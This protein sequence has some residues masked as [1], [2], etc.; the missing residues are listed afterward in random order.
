MTSSLKWIYVLT[1][2]QAI[3]GL[4]A[5]ASIQTG[6]GFTGVD[7][8]NNIPLRILPLGASI[9]WGQNSPTGNGYR[10]HLRTQIVSA[11]W[12]VDM[13]GSKKNGDMIDNDVEAHPGDTI[14]QVAAA[15]QNSYVYK[16]NI[17]LINAGT[18][19]CRLNI[20]IS[21]AGERMRS[22]IQGLLDAAD[23]NAKPLIV[24]STLLP[25]GQPE[26]A[27]NSPSVNAQYRQLVQDMRNQGVKIVLAEMNGAN[28][29]IQYPADY[30]NPTTGQVD[31]AHPNDEGYRKMAAIWYE[32]IVGAAGQEL[33][34]SSPAAIL[35]TP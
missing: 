23:P 15:S 8:A 21:S 4:A 14:T 17:V 31:D 1:I 16:P 26:I 33:V 12:L 3:S 30:T 20:G 27:R 22:L 13:V 35:S 11:G 10:L 25:S 7:S 18:N 32:A 6:S 2:L 28:Q 9:T 29:R 34:S 19:D 24:L 5:P